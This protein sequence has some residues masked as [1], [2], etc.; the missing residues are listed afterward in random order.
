MYA[1]NFRQLDIEYCQDF[2]QNLLPNPRVVLSMACVYLKSIVEAHCVRIWAENKSRIQGSDI[3]LFTLPVFHSS[4]K[5]PKR[6]CE[7]H[8]CI[9]SK[10]GQTLEARADRLL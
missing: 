1:Y 8:F 2:L 10:F 9:R 3:Y 7:I 6:Y 4:Q 5:K